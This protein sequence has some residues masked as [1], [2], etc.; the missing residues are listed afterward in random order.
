MKILVDT[1]VHTISSGHAYSTIDEIAHYAKSKNLEAV[2]MTDHSDGMPGGAHLYH[3]ANIRIL[4]DYMHGVRIFKGVETNIMDYDGNLDM[5]DWQLEHLDIVI[6]SLHPPCIP[7]ADKEIITRTL[8]KTIENPNVHIIGH[9]GDSRYPMD[10]E[11]VVKHA[12]AHKVLLEVNN[13]SLR[14]TSVRKGVREN[15]VEILKECI[16]QDNPIVVATDA[17]YH[18]DVGSLEESIQLLKELNFPEHLVMNKNK[19]RLMDFIEK[20]GN[21]DEAND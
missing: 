3:F 4:P 14:P 8:M 5:E 16:K 21:T 7:F 9:P 17:H 12:K 10:V 20:R 15:L 19:K 11:K 18:E 1:H 13:A 6:A 2:A